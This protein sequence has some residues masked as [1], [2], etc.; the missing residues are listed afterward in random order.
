MYAIFAYI[1]HKNNL[2]VA[3]NT[4]P[5]DPI[6]D[7]NLK[8]LKTNKWIIP[9]I[10]HIWN[11][12]AFVERRKQMLEA[13]ADSFFRAFRNSVKPRVDGW[14][15]WNHQCLNIQHLNA[16]DI[17]VLCV[18]FEKGHFLFSGMSENFSRNLMNR[19]RDTPQKFNIDTNNGDI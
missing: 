17:C 12:K 2:N 11:S 16:F 14:I 15:Y 4:S 10:F 3:K 18:C 19:T 6:W 9:N 1:Y 8:P 7:M 5:V 13:F